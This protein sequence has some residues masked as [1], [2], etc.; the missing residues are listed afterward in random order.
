MAVAAV[1]MKVLALLIPEVMP[2]LK[3]VQMD[4]AALGFTLLISVVT[5]LVF[6]SKL[7]TGR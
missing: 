4:G 7:A 2:R 6:P 5:G 1:G 3:P